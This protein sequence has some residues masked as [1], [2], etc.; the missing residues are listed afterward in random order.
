MFVE[1]DDRVFLGVAVAEVADDG[2]HVGPVEELQDLG[3]AQLVEVD[4]RPAGLAAASAHAQE[5]LHQL[6]EERVRPHVGGE[7][8][9]GAPP[10]VGDARREQAIG[11]GLGVHVGEAGLVQVVDERGPGTPS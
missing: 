9:G 8:V 1:V 10:G 3:D 11:N 2:L 5:D 6:P 4:A 7:V